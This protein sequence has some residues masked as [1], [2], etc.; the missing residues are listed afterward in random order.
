MSVDLL[1]FAQS[2]AL[3]PETTRFVL[4]VLRG[5]RVIADQ[6]GKLERKSNRTAVSLQVSQYK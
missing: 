4:A 2:L 5:G 6:I 1:T 3:F